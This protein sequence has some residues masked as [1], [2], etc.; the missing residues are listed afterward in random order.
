MASNE[1]RVVFLVCSSSS[2]GTSFS[3]LFF[4]VSWYQFLWI[5]LLRLVVPVSLDCSSSSRVTSF[6]GLFF[7]V[8]WYQFLWIVLLRLVL[9]VSLDCSSSSRVTSFSGLYFLIAPSNVYLH[10]QHATIKI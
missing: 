10:S 3:G 7:F 9:P 5:V 8:S 2:R 6:S 4:F 1:Y